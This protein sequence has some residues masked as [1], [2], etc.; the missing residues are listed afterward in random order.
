MNKKILLLSGYDATSHRYWRNTLAE[1][2]SDYDWTQIAMPDR[3]FYWRVRGNSLGFAFDHQETLNQHYDLMIVTSMVDLSSLRGFCPSLTTI[4]T[5]VYFHENQFAYPQSEYRTNLVNVQLTSIYNALC[6]DKILF[7]SQFNLS[8]FLSGARAL[9]KRF[10]DLVPK[11]LVE[12]IESRA[13]VLAVPINVSQPDSLEQQKQIQQIP[14]IVWNHRW[15]YDKQPQVVF[16]ALAKLKAQ[17]F[18]F[19]LHVLGQSFRKQPECF[20]QAKLQFADQI[21]TFGFQPKQKYLD[22]LSQSDFVISSALHDFQGLSLQEGITLGC[23]PIAPDRVAYPEYVA[24]SNL[25]KT[26][27]NPDMEAESLFLK[28]AELIN[29]KQQMLTDISSYHS[30]RLIPL[31]KKTIESLC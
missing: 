26:S 22:I 27:D 8:S 20:E 2:L 19:R 3:H 15:E 30:N 9:L 18:D 31:Y 11:G 6:G 17:G 12:R 1:K 24:P 28:I 29:S 23:I 10:P 13:E 16:D 25:Y 14:H 7:N 21:L 4:P 5:I